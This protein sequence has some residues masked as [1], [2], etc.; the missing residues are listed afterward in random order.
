MMRLQVYDT[1]FISEH[2]SVI[3]LNYCYLFKMKLQNNQ[4]LTS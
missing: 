2:V 3:S 1:L 4:A